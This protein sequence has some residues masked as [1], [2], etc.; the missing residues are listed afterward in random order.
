MKTFLVKFQ[1]Q[2]S[3]WFN[4]IE[5]VHEFANR[6]EDMGVYYFSVQMFVDNRLT[7]EVFYTN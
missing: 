3:E 5:Q 2:V 7:K 6:L 1:D 4:S